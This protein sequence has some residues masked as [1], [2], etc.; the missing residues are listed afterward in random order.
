MLAVKIIVSRVYNKIG[1]FFLFDMAAVSERLAESESEVII[2]VVDFLR[3][4]FSVAIII[5]VI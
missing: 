3:D 4:F 5:S 1:P 2:T